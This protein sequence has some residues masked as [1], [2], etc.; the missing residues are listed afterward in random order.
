LI[1]EFAE[2]NA[3]ELKID[4][5]LEGFKKAYNLENNEYF[6]STVTFEKKYNTLKRKIEI[7]K[8]KNN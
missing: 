5:K 2:V 7:V 4:V 8:N 1:T 3:K 6:K